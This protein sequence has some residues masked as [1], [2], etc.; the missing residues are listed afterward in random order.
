V[1]APTV[2]LLAICQRLVDPDARPIR[3]HAGHNGTSI[4]RAATNA[5]AVI[6]KI[7]RSAERHEQE[8]HAYQHWVP[9]LG[10]RAPQLLAI[11]DDPPAIVV[12]CLP[13]VLLSDARLNPKDEADAYRQAGELLRL[14]HGAGPALLEP[15]MTARLGERGEHWL[16]LGRDVIGAQEAAEVRAHLSLL[17]QLAP[18]PAVPCHLDYMPR[19]LLVGPTGE[20]S[21]I[22][23][24][25]TRY[26][27]AARDLVRLA[28]RV[29]SA[30]PT[31]KGAFL[32]GY[33]RLSSLDEA[34][35]QHCRRLDRLTARV[36]MLGR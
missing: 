16:E 29:W 35:I 4:L 17:T 22:D 33:G 14:L 24:E 30:R 10:P 12:T 13:G 11:N 20:V 21:V 34:V 7:H 9:A 23:F 18:V 15:D 36:R 1:T 3:L 19:N 6:V 26:D 28:D 27:L 25:H 31:I 32:A 5:G 2:E 8:V